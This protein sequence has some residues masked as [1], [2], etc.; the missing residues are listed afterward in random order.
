MTI[1]TIIVPSDTAECGRIET[2]LQDFVAMGHAVSELQIVL[3]QETETWNENAEKNNSWTLL[4]LVFHNINAVQQLQTVQ[5]P[6]NV[7]IFW[8]ISLYSLI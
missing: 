7:F 5:E 6:Q 4:N 8:S 2:Y 1:W 3:R